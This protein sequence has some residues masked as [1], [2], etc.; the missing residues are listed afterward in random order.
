MSRAVRIPG[1]THKPVRIFG[2]KV[3]YKIQTLDGQTIFEADPLSTRTAPK[4][5]QAVGCRRRWTTRL[6]GVS[7]GPVYLQLCP[8]HTQLLIGDVE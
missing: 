1:A 6:I 5:C 3:L 8:D 2:S 4:T 7:A